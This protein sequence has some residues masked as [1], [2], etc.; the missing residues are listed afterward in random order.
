[1]R[2]F[3][4]T[5]TVEI[6]RQARSN[7]CAKCSAAQYAP[8]RPSTAHISIDELLRLRRRDDLICRGL[9]RAV[10]GRLYDAIQT[11]GRAA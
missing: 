9:D 11:G 5:N 4:C 2:C 7:A 10:R 8:K 6:E 1:M 3:F